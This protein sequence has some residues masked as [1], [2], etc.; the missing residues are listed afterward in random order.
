ML[1]TQVWYL[2][3]KTKFNVVSFDPLDITNVTLSKAAIDGDFEEIKLLDV[4]SLII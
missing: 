4:T 1:T 3:K 2:Y